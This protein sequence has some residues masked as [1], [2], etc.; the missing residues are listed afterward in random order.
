MDSRDP[1]LAIS[2]VTVPESDGLPTLDPPPIVSPGVAVTLNVP[3]GKAAH[4]WDDPGDG[5]HHQ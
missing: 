3:S 5:N 4:P 1:T 2:D